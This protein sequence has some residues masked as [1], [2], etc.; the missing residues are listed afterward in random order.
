M[1]A[2]GVLI[3]VAA[4]AWQA[5]PGMAQAPDAAARPQADQSWQD[6]CA[7]EIRQ[8]CRDQHAGPPRSCLFRREDELSDACWDVLIK[9]GRFG[10]A[11]F[12]DLNKFCRGG[13]SQLPGCLDRNLKQLTGGCRAFLEGKRVTRDG[14][15]HAGRARSTPPENK[16]N[17]A[18]G[19]KPSG[20]KK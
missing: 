20:G 10:K 12:E 6:A 15:I 8:L 13:P 3:A 18:N 2:R 19:E 11:C 9:P 1:K 7:E 16:K 5:A 14:R 17:Q 4:V